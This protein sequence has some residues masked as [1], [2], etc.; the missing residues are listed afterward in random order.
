[1]RPP[2]RYYGGA[3]PVRRFSQV[4]PRGS[5]RRGVRGLRPTSTWSWAPSA[6]GRHSCAV[7]GPPV[8]GAR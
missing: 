1:M 3:A 5:F 6:P 8:T 4:L 2:L 7:A